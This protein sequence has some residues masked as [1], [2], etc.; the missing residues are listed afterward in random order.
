MSF[1]GPG[2]DYAP[3]GTYD[4]HLLV[5]DESALPPSPRPWRPCP[6]APRRRGRRGRLRD[7]GAAARL[8][9][10]PRR[11]L[12]AARRAPWPC[13]GEALIEA[14]ESLTFLPGQPQVFLHGDAGFVRTLRRHFRVE[15]QVPV[16]ALSASGYWRRGV[17]K[18][19]GAR[20]SP[21]G[22]R[23]WRVTRSPRGVRAAGTTATRLRRTGKAGGPPC[24]SRA[25]C[26]TAALDAWGAVRVR[27]PAPPRRHAGRGP[28]GSARMRGRP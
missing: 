28:A 18:R 19:D 3:S 10:R 7:R 1:L 6:T 15:R 27:S 9:R 23:L 26:G 22:R 13:A 24:D 11:A 14:V 17:P 20:R 8:A 2:G 21:R 12:G 25:G 5:G 16:T 4:W